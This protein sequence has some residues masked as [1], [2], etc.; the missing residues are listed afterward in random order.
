[1][2]LVLRGKAKGQRAYGG[3]ACGL[4]EMATRRSGTGTKWVNAHV[5]EEV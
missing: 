4:Q 2:C 3:G 1:V 5:G